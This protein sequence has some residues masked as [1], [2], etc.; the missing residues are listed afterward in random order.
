M[1]PDPEPFAGLPLDE[2][3]IDDETWDRA[4][5]ALAAAEGDAPSGGEIP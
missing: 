2:P 5:K 4:G 1:A 3:L